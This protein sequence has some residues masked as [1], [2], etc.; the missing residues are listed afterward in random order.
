[1]SGLKFLF[2]EVLIGVWE[3]D[4]VFFLSGCDVDEIEVVMEC[5]LFE[6]FD[7][8]WNWYFV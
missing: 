5:L 3:D 1:M 6:G 8:E 7:N 2:F 4:G